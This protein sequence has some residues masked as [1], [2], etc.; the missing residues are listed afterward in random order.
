L[1]REAIVDAAIDLLDRSGSDR[2]T[3]R[4]LGHELG[5]DATACYRHFRDKSAL[6]RAVGD[7]LLS[8]VTDDLPAEADW[9]QTVQIV[10][11]RLRAALLRQPP[12][13]A[14]VRDAPPLADG[15]FAITEALL[16]QF[17]RAGLSPQHAALAYHSAIELTVGSAT[18]DASIDALGDI[19]RERMYDSWRQAYATLPI[20]DYPASRA[21]A[22]EL[23]RGTADERFT[24]A[25]ERLLDGIA[26][27]H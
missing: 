24:V 25:L 9:R 11:Q 10:C 2:L 17:L 6:L 27:R 23:Y 7:R 13:A 21:V 19:E 5:M 15:E 22:D 26:A 8:E 4:N 14:A 3:M 20:D 12:L 16:A 1:T 18:I